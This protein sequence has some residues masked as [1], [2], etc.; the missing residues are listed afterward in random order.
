MRENKHLDTA[1]D[2]VWWEVLDMIL[3]VV[4]GAGGGIVLAWACLQAMF[5]A[6]RMGWL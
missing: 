3:T 1:D 2:G 6:E 5:W 4:I